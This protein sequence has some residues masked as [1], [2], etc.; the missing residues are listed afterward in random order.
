MILNGTTSLVQEALKNGFLQPIS[1]QQIDL[2]TPSMGLN[3][4]A[5]AE[6]CE[7]AKRIP[8]VN[9]GEQKAMCMINEDASIPEQVHLTCVTE[10]TT[11]YARIITLMG[12][13]YLFPPQSSF[14]LSDISYMKPLLDCKYISC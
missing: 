14:L 12:H 5:L 6:L 10:N 9:E 2:K 11:D 1:T 13:K 8:P 4:C 7:M 3:D